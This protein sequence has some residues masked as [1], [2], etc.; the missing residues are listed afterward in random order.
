[1]VREIDMYPDRKKFIEWMG[2]KYSPITVKI[3]LYYFNV[4]EGK[5]MTVKTIEEIT[6]KPQTIEIKKND[7]ISKITLKPTRVFKSFLRTY[8]RSIKRDYLIKEIDSREDKKVK[9]KLVPLT[10]EEVE[11]LIKGASIRK[12]ILILLMYDCGMRVAEALGIS[13]EKIDWEENTILYIAKGN[14]E[15]LALMSNRLTDAIKTITLEKKRRKG[16][17]FRYKVDNAQK[18][19]KRLG[20]KILD[21]DIHPHLLRHSSASY[22]LQQGMNVVEVQHFLGHKHLATTGIYSHILKEQ[23]SKE[24][25]AKIFDKN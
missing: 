13:V 9:K 2:K 3:Y 25:G 11:K 6:K 20:K 1:M 15:R 18:I 7:I 10:N 4:I 24:K 21:K 22:L 17:I 23:E 8:L 19:I 12:K 5:R 14:E 16:K